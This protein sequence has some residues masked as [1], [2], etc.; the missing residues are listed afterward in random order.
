MG[1][2][3]TLG[4]SQVSELEKWRALGYSDDEI[5]RAIAAYYPFVQE[6]KRQGLPYFGIS[7]F[8]EP[9]VEETEE[10]IAEAVADMTQR[11]LEQRRR[12]NGDAGPSDVHS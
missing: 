1:D 3:E 2:N 8:E 12:Q 10:E 9:E 7:D 6:M 11:L 5:G 4:R